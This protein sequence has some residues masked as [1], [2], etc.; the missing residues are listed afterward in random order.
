L[1]YELQAC[2]LGHDAT[3]IFIFRR[4]VYCGVLLCVSLPLALALVQ[5]VPVIDRFDTRA[6]SDL[7]FRLLLPRQ[8]LASR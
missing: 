3:F 5:A 6:V 7:R 1:L 2:L 8:L 4:T